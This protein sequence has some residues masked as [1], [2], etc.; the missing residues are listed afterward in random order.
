MFVTAVCFLFLLKLKWPKN[1]N[2]YEP[3]RMFYELSY[4]KI[5]TRSFRLNVLNRVSKIG[6]CLNR[7]GKSAICVLNRVRVRGA[8]RTFSTQEYIGYP[9]TPARGGGGGGVLR[10][11]V[12]SFLC[13]GPMMRKSGAQT[14]LN[15][16][17][18]VI[19]LDIWN[20]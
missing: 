20:A 5:F 19:R 7:V 14:K 17:C 2:V 15:Q 6:F 16:Y 18:L 10:V 12:L 3:A 9:P 1:K 13:S 11:P 8:G 4:S